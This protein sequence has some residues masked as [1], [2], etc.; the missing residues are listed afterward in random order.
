L[1]SAVEVFVLAQFHS[2]HIDRAIRP[3]PARTQQHPAVGFFVMRE[4]HEPRRQIDFPIDQPC[5]ARAA[6][7]ALA[8]MAQVEALPQRGEQNRLAVA[9]GKG[10]I[11]R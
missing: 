2:A 11:E 1:I 9:A 4:S 5:F 8:A 6:A 10:V 7:T 3:G